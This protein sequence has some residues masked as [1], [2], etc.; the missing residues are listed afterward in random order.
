VSTCQPKLCPLPHVDEL[1]ARRTAW[2]TARLAGLT[3]PPDDPRPLAA[4]AERASALTTS[5]R[6]AL[7]LDLSEEDT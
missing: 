4:L 3:A 1:A 7:D 5:L 2:Q 6:T